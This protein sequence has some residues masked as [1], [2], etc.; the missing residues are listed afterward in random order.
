MELRYLY[1]AVI[2]ALLHATEHA[3]RLFRPTRAAL[4][5]AVYRGYCGL[6]VTNV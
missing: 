4:Q 6:N 2:M 1:L 3:L 5:N